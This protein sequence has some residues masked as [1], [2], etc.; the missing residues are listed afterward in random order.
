MARIPQESGLFTRRHADAPVT[1]QTASP[2]LFRPL[3]LR[4]QATMLAVIVMPFLALVWALIFTRPTFLNVSLL[5]G[6]WLATGFGITIGYHRY[7]THGGFKTSP[8]FQVCLAILGLMSWMGT[9]TDWVGNHLAHHQHSD[10]E[11][12]L[13]S[14]HAYRERRLDWAGGFFHAHIGWM[15]K[16]RIDNHQDYLPVRISE[17]RR[18]QFL[19]RWL[20]L[21]LALSLAI[22]PVIGGLVTHSWYG[23]WT[24]FIWGSLVRIG[25]V[26]HITWSVNSICHMYGSQPFKTGDQ[27]RNNLLISVLSLGEGSHNC[28]HRFLR[29]PKHGLLKW[30][31][32]PS[33][34]VIR[35]LELMRVVSGASAAVPD[36]R[37]IQQAL[38]E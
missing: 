31:I 22:P 26:H 6:G 7:F 1:K 24:A 20:P 12:D 36:R 16:R 19:D 21:W 32:D 14:P 17:N 38:E 37:R 25:L 33:W 27:S 34:Y 3:N 4:Q 13:H 8:A 15:L 23:A 10:G 30:Q 28:H 29:S 2:I 35:S 5:V 9:I 18:I 11:N